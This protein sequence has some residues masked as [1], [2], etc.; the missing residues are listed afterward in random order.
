MC[1][2]QMADVKQNHPGR[3]GGFVAVPLPD[4]EGAIAELR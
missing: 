4:V 2:D 3:Y 1:N